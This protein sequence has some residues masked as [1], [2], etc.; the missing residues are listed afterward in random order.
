MEHHI[1]WRK[2]NIYLR[3][4]SNKRKT[5]G[6]SLQSEQAWGVC[7]SKA[8]YVELKLKPMCP[9]LWAMRKNL[10]E[11]SWVRR[12]L[13]SPFFR[14]FVSALRRKRASMCGRRSERNNWPLPVRLFLRGTKIGFM[15][16]MSSV[17]RSSSTICK[18][19]LRGCGNVMKL[20]MSAHLFCYTLYLHLFYRSLASKMW[21]N[22]PV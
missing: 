4:A 20:E 14:T 11:A 13:L 3:K 12:W 16:F 6:S 15:S 19:R 21:Q 9:Q 8:E 18:K 17:L 10:Q 7:D 22:K 5:A 1:F 2:S